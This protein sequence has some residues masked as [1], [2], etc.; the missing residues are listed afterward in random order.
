MWVDFHNHCLPEMDDGSRSAEMSEHMLQMLAEQGVATVVA[1]PHYIAH[2]ESMEDFLQRRSQAY[3]RLRQRCAGRGLPEV[4]LGAEVRLERDLS[5]MSLQPLC[6]EGTN[7]ILLELPSVPLKSW[8]A[9]EIRNVAY[10]LKAVPILAHIDRYF[11]YYT[12]SDYEQLLSIEEAVLQVNIES[13][14]DR[15]FRNFAEKLMK[16]GYPLVW[17]RM[18]TTMHD[19]GPISILRRTWSAK[20]RYSPADGLTKGRLTARPN[21]PGRQLF[22]KNSRRPPFE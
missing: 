17:G 1:T 15:K 6:M 14:T 9:E 10:G 16:A 22:R 4:Y 2:R 11:T 13:L 8:M 20:V 12:K 7:W 19:I 18:R 3:K 21:C 5:N